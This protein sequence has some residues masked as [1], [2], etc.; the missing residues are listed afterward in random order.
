VVL[1]AMTHEITIPDR[2]A[3][4]QFEKL[5]G[6]EIRGY[7]VK[8]AHEAYVKHARE[9]QAILLDAASRTATRRG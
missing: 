9:I 2:I 6:H 4:E 8:V 5:L 7:R 3:L 1:A